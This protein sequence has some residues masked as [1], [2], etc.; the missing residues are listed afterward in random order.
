MESNLINPKLIS[1]RQ[2]SLERTE[3]SREDRLT[4]TP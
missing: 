1:Q 4:A 2:F 3:N